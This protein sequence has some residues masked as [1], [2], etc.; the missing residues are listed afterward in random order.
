MPKVLALDLDGTLF[1][2]K[3]RI[4][5][6]SKRNINFIRRFIDEGNK[7]V[8]CS[9]RNMPY[10]LKVQE[11]LDRKIDVIGCNSSFIYSNGELIKSSAMRAPEVGAMVKEFSD[12]FGIQVWLLM[13]KKQ[14]LVIAGK[15]GRIARW[16]Y[17]FIYFTHGI[18]AEKYVIS[19]DIFKEE[20]ETGE[21]YKLM[22]FFGLGKKGKNR[23]CEANKYI[24][25]H[26][27][28][29]VEASWTDNFIELTAPNVS[30]SNGLKDYCKLNNIDLNDVYVVGDSGN[31]ISMFQ[32]FYEHSFCMK[33]SPDKIKKF[34]KY[35]V[36]RV[37]DIEKLIKEIK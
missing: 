1:Y 16:V 6:I 3:K 31:D 32:A 27:Q 28:D 15:L 12:K 13:S 9:G 5:M 33:H 18:Y 36:N 22:M 21:I 7:V 37:A 10:A 20:I 17:T 34:A 35:H 19:N 23:A 4:R 2:P 25:E 26:Y 14:S 30:K 24:R 29:K 8:I 11:K